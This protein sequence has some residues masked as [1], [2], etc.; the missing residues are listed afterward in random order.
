M[1]LSPEKIEDLFNAVVSLET[2][3]ERADYLNR[4]CADTRLRNEVESLLANHQNP[5]QIFSERTRPSSYDFN[6]T[7]GTVI[8]HYTLLEIIGEGGCGIVYK[9][10]QIQPVKRLVALKIIK[11]GMDTKEVIARFETERHALAMM[12]H[13][14]IA[15]VLDAGRTDCGRPYFVMELIPGIPFTKYCDLAKITTH[16]RLLLFMEVCRAIQHAHQKGIIHRDIKPSNILVMMQDGV[17]ATKVIDFGIAKATQGRLSEGTVYTQ[18]HE[19]LGTPAYM[20]PEQTE[21]ST[22]DIDTRSDIY[23]LGVLLYELLTGKPPFDSQALLSKGLESMRKTI[24][25]VDPPPPSKLLANLDDVER[26]TTASLRTTDI[27]RLSRL[28]SGDLDWIVMKCLEKDRTRRYDTSSGLAADIEHH[29]KNEPITAIQPSLAYKLKKAY[30]RNKLSFTS[31][32][33][34][35]TALVIGFTVS[36]LQTIRATKAERE[37]HQLREI[38]DK[39][40][41]NEALERQKAE[42]AYKL[43]VKSQRE[44][45]LLLYASDMT[46]AQQSLLDNQFGLARRF[47][48]RHRPQSDEQDI[49]N[50]EWRFLWQKTQGSALL[51]L[52]N[53]PSMGF[54]A[55]FSPNG[56][57]LAVGW[58]RGSEDASVDLWD[59]PQRRLLRTW[60]E[61]GNV[62]Y[63]GHVAFSPAA[64][65]LAATTAFKTVSLHHLESGE[66]SIIWQAPAEGWWSVRDLVFSRDGSKL[67][68]YAGSSPDRG[69]GVWVMDVASHEL[70]NFFPSLCPISWWF[71]ATEF[72]PDGR[73]LYL[74]RTV[75][76]F[77]GYVIQCLDL[78]SHQEV[79]QTEVQSDAGV[80]CLAASPDGRFLVSGSGFDH[81]D[82]HLWEAS[83][84]KLLQK[85]EEHTGWITDVTFSSDGYSLVSASID[86]TIRTWSTRTWTQSSVRYGHNDGIYAV[87]LSPTQKLLA[88][89]SKDGDLMLWNMKANK[90]NTTHVRLPKQGDD[91]RVSLLD[92]SRLL[93]LSKGQSPRIIDPKSES[94]PVF[95]DTLGT[96]E[97]VIGAFEP[98]LI[99]SWDGV[100]LL[101]IHERIEEE[102]KLVGEIPLAFSQP[103]RTLAYDST[104]RRLIWSQSSPSKSVYVASLNELDR[105]PIKLKTEVDELISLQLNQGGT[106]LAGKILEKNQPGARVWNLQSGNVIASVDQWITSIA[107]A[108]GGQSLFMCP[109]GGNNIL[110]YGLADSQLIPKRIPCEYPCW[111]LTVSPDGKQV[112]GNALGGPIN[113]YDANSGNLIK[114]IIGQKGAVQSSAFSPDGLRLAS[115]SRHIKLWDVQTQQNLLTLDGNPGDVYWSRDGSMILVAGKQLDTGSI[116]VGEA[117]E[118][119]FAPSEQHILE[120]EDRI[121]VTHPE[122]FPE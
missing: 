18:F 78:M 39:A 38:A 55:S 84:G 45:R 4:M 58:A 32:A 87:A 28:L 101:K 31:V 30:L 50:W 86:G 64:D 103:L 95:L 118:A 106:I 97:N 17:P 71:G 73:Y 52:T 61:P 92:G 36:L 120:E 10:K 23:S 72:S 7:I 82:I 41:G 33:M 22:A 75:P 98:N 51:T 13:P 46:L 79:W 59:V 68:V 83:T 9:A 8:D 74:S 115:S 108:S 113:F 40:W 90:R 11:L 76:S 19:F 2:D 43:A 1:S 114:E 24:R 60:S 63:Q 102:L 96:S 107:F 62:N 69:A 105:P 119:W 21:M 26:T 112:V 117:L 116:M 3:L 42:D 67:A 14:N 81:S 121:N 16:K 94:S 29:L 34:T 54:S 6:A 85:L 65:L 111:R 89:A 25:E 49:R 99:V 44:S 104:S 110:L 91:D 37:Q 35:A 88:S 93:W 20:S 66:D 12:N 77:G 47:L 70:E 80:S 53:R 122:R 109:Q 48:D 100:Q 5:D 57:Y 27:S 56:H 15:K